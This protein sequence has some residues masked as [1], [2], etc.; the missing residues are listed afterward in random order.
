MSN[1]NVNELAKLTTT[2]EKIMYMLT[3]IVQSL[4]EHGESIKKLHK[5]LDSTIGIDIPKSAPKTTKK[6]K[7]DIISLF[8]EDYPNNKERYEPFVTNEKVTD[9]LSENG[10][11]VDA[12][13]PESVGHM[14]WSNLI[15][16]NEDA[17]NAVQGYFADQVPAKKTSKKPS[18][19]SEKPKKVDGGEDEPKP[20]KTKSKSKNDEDEPK[21]K[22]TDEDEPKPKKTKAKSKDDDSKKVDGDEPKPKKTKTKA[23]SKDDDSKKVDEDE[24]KPKAKSKDGKEKTKSKS[25]PKNEPKPDEDKPSSDIDSDFELDLS[26]SKKSACVNNDSDNE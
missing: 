17:L 12:N 13:D 3:L 21:P 1:L 25:K 23:K 9:L 11:N 8:I 14:I 7:V 10:D 16:D 22:K 19:K 4:D 2:D 18:G 6:A 5:K 20:K 26:K 15:K 24:P